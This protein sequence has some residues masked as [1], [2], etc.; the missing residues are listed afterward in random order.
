MRRRG[1]GFRERRRDPSPRYHF[2]H[3]RS[4][5]REGRRK[6]ASQRP[7]ALSHLLLLHLLHL[8]LR[9]SPPTPISLPPT[10]ELSTHCPFN[11][12]LIS[13]CSVP[14]DR[15]HGMVIMR[16]RARKSMPRLL[17]SARTHQT[18]SGTPT[19]V[20]W[21]GLA[22]RGM[23]GRVGGGGARARWQ[24]RLTPFACRRFNVNFAIQCKPIWRR[25]SL[26]VLCSELPLLPSNPRPRRHRR[27]T[28]AAA[29]PTTHSSR[30]SSEGH[31]V[32]G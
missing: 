8:P 5:H 11:Q 15:C 20:A 29:T 27:P 6:R 23:M 18:R 1:T 9:A 19:E 12:D 24:E 17:A 32:S 3:A 28:P 13:G 26:H 30:K 16:P 10:V 21:P 14:R 7:G 25:L 22:V 31:E 2:L 4:E